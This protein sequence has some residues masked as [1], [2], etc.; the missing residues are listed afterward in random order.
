MG[1]LK[2]VDDPAGWL[3]DDFSGPRD[4]THVLSPGE[5]AD[6]DAAVAAIEARGL[7]IV[8][9]GRGDFDLPVLGPVLTDI[10]RALLHGRGFA[11]LRGLPV[12]RMSRRQVGIA[13]YGIGTHLGRAV[14]QNGKGHVL[15]HVKSLDRGDLETPTN[16]GYQTGAGLPWHCDS[17]DVVALLCLQPA[18]SGGTSVIAS[19]VSIYNTLVA[20]RPDLA[21]ALAEP[22][23]RDRRGE[24]PA[25]KLPY[26]RMPIV[27]VHVGRLIVSYQGGYIRTA[28]RFEDLPRFTELQTEALEAI[29]DLAEELHLDLTFEPGDIQ[30]LHNHVMIHARRDYEDFPEPERKRHLMRLWLSTPEGRAL[31]DWFA[32]RYHALGSGQ[33]PSGGIIL[34]GTRL[35]APLDT[36]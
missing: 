27:M 13:F 36:E 34:P 23:Y 2:S 28:Q 30:L 31:P 7:D 17:C 29:V 15:G 3:G 19:S 12:G 32:E 20:R 24:V 11:V 8:D 4:W 16:R 26:Y 1:A 18:K 25:G 21:R 10:E 22:W 5:I 14:S 33:R 35:T 9:I 6:V